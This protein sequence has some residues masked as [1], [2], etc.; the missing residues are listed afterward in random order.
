MHAR[1]RKAGGTNL[2]SALIAHCT[3]HRRGGELGSRV[4]TGQRLR[5]HVSAGHPHL[6]QVDSS[7]T[8]QLHLVAE[9]HRPH[10][11]YRPQAVRL[12]VCSQRR[13]LL[14]IAVGRLLW[15]SG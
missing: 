2:R 9:R 6:I 1:A 8:G 11:H 3:L 12:S 10:H 7:F 4:G 14:A 5:F 15:R 13:P